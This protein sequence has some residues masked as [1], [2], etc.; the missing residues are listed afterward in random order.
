MTTSVAGIYDNFGQASY[1]TMMLGLVGIGKTLAIEGASKNVFVNAIAPAAG[2]RLTATALPQD[3]VN[4]LKPKY[5]TPTMVLRCHA[6]STV[7]GRLFEVGAAGPARRGADRGVCFEHA[8][9]AENV[10]ARWNEA[11][12]FG[13]ARHANS[14]TELKM[15]FKERLGR[16]FVLAP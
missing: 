7:T 8:F 9:S 6:D 10:R 12:S 5:V 2:S 13:N 4:V 3:V 16:D 15:D 14:V 1:S 11:T